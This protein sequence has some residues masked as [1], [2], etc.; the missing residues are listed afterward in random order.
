MHKPKQVKRIR[1]REIVAFMRNA[2]MML[3]GLLSS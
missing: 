2:L 1:I 3:L